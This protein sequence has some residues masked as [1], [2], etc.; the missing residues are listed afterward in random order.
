[1][2]DYTGGT[3]VITLALKSGERKLMSQSKDVM[4]GWQKRFKV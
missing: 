1:M 2:L 3:N 4:E